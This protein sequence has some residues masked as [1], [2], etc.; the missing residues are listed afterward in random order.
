MEK[1]DQITPQKETNNMFQ[2]SHLDFVHPPLS[3]QNP[4]W[5]TSIDRVNNATHERNQSSLQY[6]WLHGSEIQPTSENW[7]ALMY[8]YIQSK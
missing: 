6:S 5:L 4:S 8:V 1:K 2:A 3:L 7:Q